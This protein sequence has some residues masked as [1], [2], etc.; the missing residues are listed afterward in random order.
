MSS[1]K[2][3]GR[4]NCFDTD[5]RLSSEMLSKPIESTR[6]PERATRSS[7]SGS[8]AMLIV[9]WLTHCTRSGIERGEHLLRLLGVGDR[10]V[11]EEEEAVRAEPLH[12]GGSRR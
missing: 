5:A 4:L 3:L 1:P 11:V 8:R 12:A 6:Q 10:V 2:R 9:A 7:S